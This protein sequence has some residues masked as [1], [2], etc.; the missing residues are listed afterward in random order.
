MER[1]PLETR[2]FKKMRNSN[3]TTLKARKRAA[4]PHHIIPAKLLDAA[5]ELFFSEGYEHVTVQAIVTRA[6]G[7]KS[8]VYKHFGGKEGLLFAVVERES[9]ALRKPLDEID[10]ASLPVD[11]A[12]RKIADV[13]LSVVYAEKTIA[14]HRL[15]I[16]QSGRFPGLASTF[17]SHGP[18]GS[19]A[20]VARVFKEWQRSGIL[21]ASRDVNVL[22]R[23]FLDLTKL[24]EHSHLLLGMK[25]ETPKQRSH[26]VEEAIKTFCTGVQREVR[27]QRS[28]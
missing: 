23:Q 4:G 24:N 14:L 26:V 19:T 27:R 6:G 28:D 11:R 25:S 16:G 3:S 12:L 8:N 7:S 22:A 21:S 13:F 10:V 2:I 1:T 17:V 18:E 20:A 9:A 15:V 5:T